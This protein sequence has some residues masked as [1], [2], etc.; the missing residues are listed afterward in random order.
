[1]VFDDDLGLSCDVMSSQISDEKLVEL[2]DS[3]ASFDFDDVVGLS[4]VIACLWHSDDELDASCDFSVLKVSDAA[5]NFFKADK[6]PLSWKKHEKVRRSDFTLIQHRFIF[7]LSRR[8][9]PFIHVL[10]ES[11]SWNDCRISNRNSPLAVPC[12]GD[13]SSVLS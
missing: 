9:L 13:L 1:M 5:V 10:Q 4:W 3:F 12:F 7:R 8:L 6:N 11:E 2:R